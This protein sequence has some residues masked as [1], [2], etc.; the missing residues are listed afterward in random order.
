MNLLDK[1][2]GFAESAHTWILAGMPVVDQATYDR[3]MYIC[4]NCPDYIDGKCKHCGCYMKTKCWLATE[5]CARPDKPL[6]D[7]EVKE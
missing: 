7:A 1:L 6:W 3:R 5:G 4:S 2:K